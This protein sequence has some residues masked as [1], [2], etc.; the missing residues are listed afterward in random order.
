MINITESLYFT[1]TLQ[2]VGIILQLV[3]VYWIVRLAIRHER[4][5][6]DTILIL[7]N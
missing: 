1:Q 2:I 3:G 6:I 5:K 4:K 7:W